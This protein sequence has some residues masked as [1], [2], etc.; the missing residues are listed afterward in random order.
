MKKNSTK[1]K[2]YAIYLNKWLNQYL[3]KTKKTGYILG[4]SGGI[5]SALCLTLC[6]NY[7][8]IHVEPIY[9]NIENSALDSQCIKALA[10]QYQIKINEINLENIYHTIAKQLKIADSLSLSNLKSRLRMLSLYAIAQQ[11]NLLVMGTSNAD[12]LYLGYYT[13]YGDGASDISPLACLTKNNIF[14]LAK[15]LNL[16]QIIISRPPSASLYKNQTDEQDLGF[17]YHDLDQFLLGKKI[18]QKIEQKIVN[19]HKRNLH[20]NTLINKPKQYQKLKIIN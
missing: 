4:L 12:E 18:N 16:P 10:K 13:K 15:L 2:E 20:K 17:T 5:D 9:L 7:K 19:Y 14:D 11:K 8:E 3:I 1:L 6:K